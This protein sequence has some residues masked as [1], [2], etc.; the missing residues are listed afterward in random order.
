[1]VPFLGKIFGSKAVGF[2]CKSLNALISQFAVN[3]LF[4]AF[5]VEMAD[6]RTD[7]S[8]SDVKSFCDRFF[9]SCQLRTGLSVQRA[10]SVA[11]PHN[12]FEPHR[13]HRDAATEADT[14]SVNQR[15]EIS[16]GTLI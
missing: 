5:E 16:H 13:Q 4:S 11:Q 12:N 8:Y 9:A 15:L 6:G 10:N 14:N 3:E 2:Q 1:M 7:Q